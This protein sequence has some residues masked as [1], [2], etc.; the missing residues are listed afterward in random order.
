MRPPANRNFVPEDS[1]ASQPRPPTFYHP[2]PQYGIAPMSMHKAQLRTI[3]QMGCI[4]QPHTNNVS[5]PLRE[6]SAM[7]RVH[8][9]TAKSYDRSGIT[10]T[11]P[12]TLSG[13]GA[14]LES[15][16]NRGNYDAT[17]RGLAVTS[18]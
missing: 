12:R 16:T 7:R 15:R 4:P 5:L 18:Y 2:Q 3:T 6:I 14:D 11:P 9:G 8:R 1:K 10:C 13:I 17:Q